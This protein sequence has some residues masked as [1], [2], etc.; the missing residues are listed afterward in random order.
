VKKIELFFHFFHFIFR[1]STVKRIKKKCSSSMKLRWLLI[2]FL[3]LSHPPSLSHTSFYKAIQALKRSRS[4]CGGKSIA[5]PTWTG[6]FYTIFMS[7]Y[8]S[9]VSDLCQFCVSFVSVLCQFCVSF[10]SFSFWFS[11]LILN[12]WM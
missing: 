6:L 8:F 11:I 3:S 4:Q 5:L 10:V 1:F 12:F 2:R 7:F 9:F